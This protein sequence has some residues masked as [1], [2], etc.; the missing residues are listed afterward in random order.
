VTEHVPELGALVLPDDEGRP[1]R[2]GEVWGD[3][4]AILAFL[5]H[6]G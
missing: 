2:L 1:T 6:Y 5:R 4:P 3:R